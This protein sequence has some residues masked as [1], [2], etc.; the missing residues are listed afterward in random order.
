MFLI[1][2][3]ILSTVFLL[4]LFANVQ[5][6]IPK[7]VVRGE[8]LFFSIEI[9]GKDIVFPDFK[10]IGSYGVQEVS[11]LTS[12]NIINSQITK[13]IKKVYSLYPTKDFVFPD[14]KFIVDGKEYLSKEQNIVLKDPQKTISTNFELSLKTDVEEL[15]V[16]EN[17]ILTLVFKYKK[18][19]N[20]VDLSF[21]K[22]NFDDFW[23]KQLDDSKQY[24]EGSFVIQELKF[25]LFPLKSGKLKINPLKINAQI[26]ESNNSF[27][28]FS[29]QHQVLKY[30]QMSWSL[31]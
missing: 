21:E 3:L 1:K 11:S 27:S 18:S 15:Y 14:L 4:S 23:Y 25:L 24:Q 6:S 26:I 12:R 22:P 29:N 20:I 9:T 31:M 7:D 2:Y 10:T 5:L 13:K 19:A 17:F 30:I 8:A 28:F 16:N